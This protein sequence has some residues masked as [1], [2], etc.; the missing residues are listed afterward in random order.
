MSLW[1][2]FECI[3][4]WAV[5]NITKQSLKC[6]DVHLQSYEKVKINKWCGAKM[7]LQVAVQ[8]GFLLSACAPFQGQSL[9]EAN[10]CPTISLPQGQQ[11]TNTVCHHDIS[12]VV[13][14]LLFITLYLNQLILSDGGGWR[15]SF[16]SIP[17]SI[18]HFLNQQHGLIS[19]SLP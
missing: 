17:Q 8:G 18:S 3:R 10:W 16:Q 6:V 19:T 5:Y 13:T 12:V 1:C 9:L 2:Y 15:V 4:W 14:S 11:P 7:K